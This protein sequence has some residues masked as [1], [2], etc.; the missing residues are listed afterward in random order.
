MNKSS[1]DLTLSLSKKE[2]NMLIEALLFSTSVNVGADWDEENID[3]MIFLSKKLK[4]Q[5]NDNSKLE[6]IVF[7]KEENYEDKWTQ[8]VFDFFKNNLNVIELQQA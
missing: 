4:T 5:L 6:H 8:S 7:Y 3:N 2:I 1:K